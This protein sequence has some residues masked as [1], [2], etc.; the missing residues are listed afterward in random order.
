MNT[1][2]PIAPAGAARQL[3]AAARLCPLALAVMSL[4]L[5]VGG[6][7]VG[8]SSS[9]S[10]TGTFVGRETLATIEPGTSTR[11]YVLATLGEPTSKR[12]LSGGEELWRWDYRRVKMSSGYVLVV[13]GGS[14]REEV[15][16]TTFVHLQGDRVK[17]VWQD[18]AAS[19]AE[20]QSCPTV[21]EI[22][23]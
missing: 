8:G 1:R 11:E 18:D 2:H 5:P 23:G 9:T 20:G 15:A 7:I 16:A 4:A 3:A 19:T 6:C 14:S 22:D 17:R 10:I 21:R 12:T 13:F